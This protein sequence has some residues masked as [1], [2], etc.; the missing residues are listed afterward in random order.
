[1]ECVK[2]ESK[3]KSG[4]EV[5][6]MQI[7]PPDPIGELGSG[8]DKIAAALKPAPTDLTIGNSD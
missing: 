4:E 3:V 8:F 1:M 6:E 7:A 2:F 5:T